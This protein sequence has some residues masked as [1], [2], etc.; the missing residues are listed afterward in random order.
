MADEP[1]GDEDLRESREAAAAAAELAGDP[2]AFGEA[3][4]A[5]EASDADRFQAVLDRVGLGQRCR[6]ICVFFCRKRCVGGCRRLCPGDPPEVTADEVR[7][8]ALAFAQLSEEEMKRL[9]EIVHRQDEAAWKEALDRHELTRFCYQ[10]CHLLCIVRCKR[11]CRELCPPAPLI[12]NIGSILTPTR[13]GPQGF[14]NGQGVPPFHVPFP[15]PP[16]GV[17]DHPFGGY[18]WVKG[19]FNMPTAT[20]YK[21]EIAD[22]P[23]GTY[24]A[25]SVAVDGTNNTATGPVPVTRTPSGSP[26]P[27]WYKVVE[28][29]DSD[30]GPF[31]FGEKRLLDWPTP[32]MPDGIYYLRLRVRDGSGTERVSAPQIAQSDNT[33]PSLPLITLELRTPA[34]ELKELK[35]GKVRRGDGL[36]RITVQA[37]DVNFGTMGVAAQGNSSLSVPVVAVPEGSPPGTL[38]V[39][40]T[41]TYN[42]DI[43]D[44]GYPAPAS[45]LWDPWSDPRIVPCCYVVRIDIYDRALSNNWWAGGHGNSGWEALEIGF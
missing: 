23:G 27:G 12:T 30:G 42:G 32:A 9:A 8:F 41:K 17:G 14:G 1:F 31:A 11:H 39:P 35:C 22:S 43:T 4:A 7:E 21:V 24:T 28:I 19:I 34:G 16:L 26:D 33:G 25:I 6:L 18:P 44:Q 29:A 3:Y 5:F 13:V 38:P 45:F 15:N 40:L 2:K 36:I 37:W 10:V 20:E